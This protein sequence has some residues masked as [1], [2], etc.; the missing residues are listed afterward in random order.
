M[1]HGRDDVVGMD[2]SILMNR[3]IWKA[4]GHEDTFT[5]PMVDCR[6]CNGALTHRP[7]D[8]EKKA[9]GNARTVEAKI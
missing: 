9:A 5:D 7:S 6:S 3:A 2:G 1:V 8:R 4:S